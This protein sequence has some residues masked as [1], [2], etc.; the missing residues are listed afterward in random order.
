MISTSNLG[1][2]EFV[3]KIHVDKLI[4]KSMSL[5]IIYLLCWVSVPNKATSNFNSNPKI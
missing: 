1:F 3:S 5:C 4:P 2:I